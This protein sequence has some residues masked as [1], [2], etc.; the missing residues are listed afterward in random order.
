MAMHIS[1]DRAEYGDEIIVLDAAG[2]V[3]ETIRPAAELA[4]MIYGDLNQDDDLTV[5]DVVLLCRCLSEDST[6]ESTAALPLCDIDRDGLLTL[7][8]S[9]IL[10]RLLQC[11]VVGSPQ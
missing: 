2:A 11:K 1:A 8:D 10:L 5:A 9:S 4:P 6:L 7:T 3:S